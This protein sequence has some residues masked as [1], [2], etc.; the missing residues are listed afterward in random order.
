MDHL[1]MGLLDR[2]SDFG[3]APKCTWGHLVG[4][5][6][7]QRFGIKG[8]LSL[9]SAPRFRKT[10]L[11]SI[12]L[13]L[14]KMI[15]RRL[16][17]KRVEEEVAN[18]EG[19][20][21]EGPQVPLD[22]QA[23]VDPANVTQAEFRAY[24][25]MISQAMTAQTQAMTIQAKT[26]T[27]QAT[28]D[29]RAHVNP[30]AGTPASRIR[31]FTSMNPSTL[32]GS[33]VDEDSQDFIDKVFKVVD[34]MGVSSQEKAKLATYQ[35]KDVAQVWFDQWRDERLVRGG[36]VD[37]ASFKM[38][39][40]DRLKGEGGNQ[41]PPSGSNSDAPKK[42]NFNAFQ[43][44]SDQEGSPNVVTVKEYPKVFPDDLPGIPPEQ[45]I[46]FGIDLM[47][48]TL[49]ISIPPYRMASAKLKE[50]KTQLKELLYKGFIQQSISS[51][52]A[53]VLF[54]NKKDGSLRMFIDYRQLNKVTI[55]IKYHLPRIDDL[56]DQL[57]GA[58]YFSKI[59]LTSGYH[60]HRMRHVDIPKT[61]FCT[62]YGHYVFLVIS[63][64]LTN[65][66]TSFMNLMNRVFREYLDSFVIVFIDDISIYSRSEADHMKHLRIVLQVL[67]DHQLYAKFCKCDFWLRSVAFLGHIVSDKGIEVDPKKM[68]A[69]KSWPRPSY[70]IDIQ[71]FLGLARY[72][73]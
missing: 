65:A 11:L 27:A 22:E 46:E 37:W 18:D 58:S 41:A 36:P 38:A 67:K 3:N 39:F 4:C 68:D 45:E 10:R 48:D 70:P 42:N 31:D 16:A 9:S 6:F 54:L 35:L 40:L 49:P 51:W 69:V 24:M 55:M 17:A 64:G 8:K 25:Q 71:N 34:N 29:V 15:I 20:P 14:R 13:S 50:L 63:F 19:V 43:S 59:D 30:N 2:P 28:R 72:Y 23:P 12:F 1:A 73:R 44:R 52:G 62:R 26:I 61:A 57:Q 66:P 21:R 32:Y 5:P 33:K 56:F 53:P 60:Q 47:M 7:G